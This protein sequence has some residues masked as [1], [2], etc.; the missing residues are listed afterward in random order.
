[1]VLSAFSA[2][3]L[4]LA[5]C[6]VCQRAGVELPVAP[7]G[8]STGERSRRCAGLAG[9]EK[10]SR[11][12]WTYKSPSPRVIAARDFIWEKPS[13]AFAWSPAK[14]EASRS[15]LREQH[16]L[17]FFRARYRPSAQA[18]GFAHEYV[19]KFRQGSAFWH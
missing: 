5:A 11:Q 12:V 2:L 9:A 14:Q 6:A 7:Q 3:K 8:R 4:L 10:A 17:L 13:S 15:S 19:C 18:L 16:D 1:L